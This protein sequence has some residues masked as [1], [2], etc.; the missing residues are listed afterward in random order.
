M[1][2]QDLKGDPVWSINSGKIDYK[3]R[4]FPGFK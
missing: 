1:H 4:D 3:S 2:N